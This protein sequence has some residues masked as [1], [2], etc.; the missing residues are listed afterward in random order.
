MDIR[1]RINAEIRE[2]TIVTCLEKNARLCGECRIPIHAQITCH[3][4]VTYIT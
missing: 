1:Q 2:L 4:C 3:V